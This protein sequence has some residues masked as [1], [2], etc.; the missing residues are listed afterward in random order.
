V[1][2]PRW[3]R[4]LLIGLAVLLVLAGAAI[5]AAAQYFDR[6]RVTGL[7]T[8][9][10]NKA[11]GRQI[12]FDGPIGFR[13]LPSLG[14]RLEGVRLANADWSKQPDMVKAKRL[15]LVVALQ[16][17]LRKQLQISSVL[18]DGVEVWLETDPKGRGN[19]VM[20]GE[21]KPAQAPQ[22]QETG[23]PMAID[24][25]AAE[26]RESTI[27][28]RDGKTGRT[29]TLGLQRVS[30][31]SAGPTDR[32][33]A[34]IRLRDQ[35]LSIKGNIAK[36]A[37]LLAGADSFP[38]DL[39][40]ALEGASVK[41]KGSI[42]LAAR[43]D[44]AS[45][46]LRAEVRQT[47][48]LAR[49]AGRELPL[50]LPLELSGRL[51]QDGARSVLPSFKLTVAGQALDGKADF[52]ASAKRPRLKLTAKAAA[53]DLGA[54]LPSL[55]KAPVAT[56]K[57]A[58]K[59]RLFTDDPLPLTELPALDAHVDLAVAKLELPGKPALS[60]LHA[61]LAL[62]DGRV[63]VEPLDFRVGS[64][65]VDGTATLRLPTG[66]APVLS[67]RARSDGVTLEEVLAMAG[68]AG[69]L[70]GGR[71]DV[72]L[73]LTATGASPHQL[74]RSLDGEVRFK[75]DRMRLSG[76]LS[77]LGGDL[78]I[79][80]VDAVSPFYKQDKGSNVECVAARLPVKRGAIVVD[81][82]IAV[83]SDKLNIVASGSIDLGAEKIEMAIRPTVKE[84]LGL[85]TANLAQ[86]VRLTGSL[87][88]PRI[89]VDLKGA[90]R[91]GLSIGAA[92]ATGGLSLLGER[93]LT[94]VVDPHPCVTAMG[95]KAPAA[96]PP[97]ATDKPQKKGFELPSP[98]RSLR[99]R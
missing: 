19:W 33:D 14:L 79:Q 12:H 59:G 24:L 27:T 4:W 45:F 30:L 77:G 20:K 61:V 54:L 2:L 32:L 22:P 8:A 68:K 5:F 92:V 16:P 83:E 44:K 15:E 11:T 67:L 69:G 64:G 75:A 78:L 49:L 47:T 58:P 76:N 98:L 57:P 90:A 73:D 60:A 28:L 48:A 43:A 74:A 51:E 88:D 7:V 18:L 82:S 36:L 26:I 96:E 56:T 89:G 95:S 31:S 39:T 52:D 23:E 29:E 62:N 38:L 85:G 66:G 10:V 37:D 94:E 97:Q 34:Q 70:S 72:Q 17:L 25:T 55:P 99:K 3:A 87:S 80:L 65:S 50:P 86:L 40:L 9:E 81:R 93:L 53:I 21:P 63:V 13:V 35:S 91:Q 71:T 6:E 41:A 42:G 1:S 46:D 84:G